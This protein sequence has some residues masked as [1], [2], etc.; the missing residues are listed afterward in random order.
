MKH[1]K[2]LIVWEKVKYKERDIKYMVISCSLINY[3]GR[4]KFD[5]FM[6]SLNYIL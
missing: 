5:K 1:E 6:C 4:T 3:Q 2:M